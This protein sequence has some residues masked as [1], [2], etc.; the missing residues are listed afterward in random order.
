MSKSGLEGVIVG[1]SRLSY[2]DGDQGELIYGGYDIDDLARNTTFEEVC[3]LLWNGKLPNRGE[4]E[5]LRREL[6]TARQ[7]DRRLLD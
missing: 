6:E 4:L 1:Q 5:G 3:Y 2:I 7:V